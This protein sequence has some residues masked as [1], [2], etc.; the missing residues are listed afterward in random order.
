MSGPIRMCAACRTHAPKGELLR[1]VRTPDGQVMADAREKIPGRGAYICR[2]A[3]C[4]RKIRKTRALERMLG[5]T[6][7]E[8][9]YNVIASMLDGENG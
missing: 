2:S 8:E 3:N 6:I 5:V 7:P 1:V 9:T 4:F